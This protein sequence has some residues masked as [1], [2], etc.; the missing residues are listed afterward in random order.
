MLPHCGKCTKATGKVQQTI[1]I[2]IKEIPV[3]VECL[4]LVKN[5]NWVKPEPKLPPAP[6]RPEMTPSERREMKGMIPNVAPQA[7]CVVIEK[8]IMERIEKGRVE[9][10]PKQIQK[11]PPRVWTI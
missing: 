8:R 10:R 2:P 11:M 6:V 5:N 9:A 3:A 4:E 1:I 7:A